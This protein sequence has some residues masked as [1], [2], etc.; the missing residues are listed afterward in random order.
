[1]RSLLDR[2]PGK[3]EAAPLCDSLDARPPADEDRCDEPHLRGPDCPLERAVVAWVGD[4]GRDRGQ[5]LAQFE[6]LLVLLVRPRHG[7]LPHL[8]PPRTF[9]ARVETL[10]ISRAAIM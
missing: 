2:E 9:A 5:R 4:H 3:V 10:P 6:Q 8:R 1:M 7:Y